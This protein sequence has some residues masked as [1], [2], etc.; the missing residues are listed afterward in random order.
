MHEVRPLRSTGITPLPRYYEPVRL[1]AEA[2][3]WLWIP[4][5]RCRRP[6]HFAGSPGTRQFSIHARPPHPPRAA[7]RVRLLVAS[8]P[9]AGFVIFGRVAA[10]SVSVTRPN[11]VRC[12]WTRVF[13]LTTRWSGRPA[14]ALPRPDRSVSRR[15]LPFDAGP[16]RHGERAIHMADT[17]QSAREKRGIPAQPKRAK[18]AKTG[19]E[20]CR[21]RTPSGGW[22]AENR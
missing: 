3:P 5:G 6:L 7:R 16:E 19:T 1:P 17:S 22:A 15:Q 18:L 13:A 10:A 11:R 14:A 8:A 21:R 9:V 12:C 4:S 2:A 20:A